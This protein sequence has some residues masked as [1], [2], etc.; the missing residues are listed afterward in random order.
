MDLLKDRK[1]PV[2]PFRCPRGLSVR[3]VERLLCFTFNG[4]RYSRPEYLVTPDSFS[5]S[6]NCLPHKLRRSA[7]HSS[8]AFSTE[9]FGEQSLS[10]M[11]YSSIGNSIKTLGEQLDNGKIVVVHIATLDQHG[12]RNWIANIVAYIR[13]IRTSWLLR[14]TGAEK[15]TSVA[16]GEY[17]CYELGGSASRYAQDHLA[18]QS[19]V[20]WKRALRKCLVWAS[21]V[22]VDSCEIVVVGLKR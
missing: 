15:V 6:T 7:L 13:I 16:V 9:G 11:S 4:A 10:V 18:W 17:V 8:L 12:V 5:P 22:T 2:E 19:T 20:T 3:Q 1:P 21:P 14:R